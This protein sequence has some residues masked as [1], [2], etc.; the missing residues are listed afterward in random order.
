[1]SAAASAILVLVNIVVT[2]RFE[3]LYGS[4]F[5]KSCSFRDPFSSRTDAPADAR[6]VW[7]GAARRQSREL[8]WGHAIG[9]RSC[10]LT[11]VTRRR[12]LPM[13]RIAEQFFLCRTSRRGSACLDCAQAR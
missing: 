2:P 3:S 13:G 12:N 4:G 10:E 9:E 1:M 11:H 6:E 7:C 5:L 8:D